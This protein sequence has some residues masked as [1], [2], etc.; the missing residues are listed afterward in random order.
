MEFEDLENRSRVG[1]AR[2]SA[3]SEAQ[4]RILWLGFMSKEVLKSNLDLGNPQRSSSEKD[5][6]SAENEMNLRTGSNPDWH[7]SRKGPMRCHRFLTDR[8]GW[9]RKSYLQ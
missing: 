3:Y 1:G 6:D 8:C 4:G 5:L 7:M 9:K 2:L